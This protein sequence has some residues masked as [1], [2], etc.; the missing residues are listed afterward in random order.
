MKFFKSFKDAKKK[1]EREKRIKAVKKI[2]MAVSIGSAVGAATGLL[3][4]PKSGKETRQDI[5]NGV[6]DASESVR[7]SAGNVKDKAIEVQKGLKDVLGN[8]RSLFAKRKG[9]KEEEGLEEQI[10]KDE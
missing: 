2:A 10:D 8:A 7:S 1:K 4:A 5:V 6:K 3:F 9:T